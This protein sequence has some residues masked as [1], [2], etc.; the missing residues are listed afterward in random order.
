MTY[1]SLTDAD[2]A[3]MLETIGVTTVEELFRDIPEGV[4]FGRALDL[5]APFSEQ[6]IV[7]R[8]EALA[9]R[10]RAAGADAPRVRALLKAA[11]LVVRAHV[12][13]ITQYDNGRVVVA[14]L[15]V[16]ETRKGGANCLI[17]VSCVV[18]RID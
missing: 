11:R 10:N 5:G 3:E 7:E 8:Q 2:R 9:D 17:N 16:D 15:R 4:R 1:V 13:D 12:V 14:A 6:E 18:R